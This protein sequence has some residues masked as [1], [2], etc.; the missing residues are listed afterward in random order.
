[1]P[2]EYKSTQETENLALEARIFLGPVTDML[3]EILKDI[4]SENG[5][6]RNVSYLMYKGIIMDYQKHIII[7]G[8]YSQFDVSL[9]CSILIDANSLNNKKRK[10]KQTSS[11]QNFATIRRLR[12]EWYGHAKT[13]YLLNTDFEKHWNEIL[14]I[15]KDLEV[16][17]L[18][19]STRYQNGVM[20]IKSCGGDSDLKCIK[21]L[22]DIEKKQLENLTG[23]YAL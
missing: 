6:K 7:G 23:K 22:L 1:M 21:R 16:G 9:L 17:E 4:I 20:N 14:K 2:F 10:L 8:D 11:P 3:R 18:V 15:V 13:Y 5:L 12:N 19:N